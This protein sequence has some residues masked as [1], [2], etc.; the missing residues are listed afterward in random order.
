[1]QVGLLDSLKYV[2]QKRIGV[3][4]GNL[5]EPLLM[6]L[7]HARDPAFQEAPELSLDKAAEMDPPATIAGPPSGSCEPSRT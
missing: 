6:L 5:I 1:M 7:Q 2:D 4:N 3:P